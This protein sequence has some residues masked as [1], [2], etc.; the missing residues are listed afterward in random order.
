MYRMWHVPHFY[1]LLSKSVV[2]REIKAPFEDVKKP[3]FD[4]KKATF[5]P[6]KS[7]F[8]KSYFRSILGE[9]PIVLCRCR[10][11]RFPVS[12]I[13]PVIIVDRIDQLTL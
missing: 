2:F 12:P 3:L 10:H 4:P 8:L 7:H 11:C 9:T 6:P 5:H 1:D 13:S